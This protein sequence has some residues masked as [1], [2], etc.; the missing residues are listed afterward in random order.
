MSLFEEDKRQTLKPVRD[1]NE[2]LLESFAAGPCS[3]IR[4]SKGN[5]DQTKYEHLHTIEIDG[6]PFNRRFAIS[7]YSDVRGALSKAWEAFY[8]TSLPL[9][10]PADIEAVRSLVQSN[11]VSRL[12]PLLEASG[13]VK[14]L[15]GTLHFRA[16]EF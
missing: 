3:C 11:A 13:V 1:F 6:A 15:D 2:L 10:G 16:E 7:S 5:G 12:A 8:K 4:C 14:S 9:R